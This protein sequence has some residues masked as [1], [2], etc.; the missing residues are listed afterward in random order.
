MKT[1]ARRYRSIV[2]LTIVCALQAEVA[3]A[4]SPAAADEGA[5]HA[6]VVPG[7]RPTLRALGVVDA[8]ERA[9]VMVELIRRLHFSA[10]PPVDLQATLLDLSTAMTDFETLRNAVA[11][12][13]PSPSLKMAADRRSRGKLEDALEAA[14][15]DLKESRRVYRVELRTNDTAAA[16]RRRLAIIGV[17]AEELQRTLN[18][19][20]ELRIE[21]R[22]I[23][24]PLPLSPQT[25]SKIIFE[26]DV[27]P[28]QL[29]SEI[30]NDPSARLLYHGLSGMD[31]GTRRWLAGQPDLL[32]RI[33]RDAEAVR[34]FSLFAAALR[35]HDGH[36]VVPGDA[37]GA[38]RWAAVLDAD[39]AR[40]DRFVRRLLDHN[41]GRT[42]GLYFTIAAVDERRRRF[43]L[44]AAGDA[45][46]ED[47][48]FKRLV[49][50]FANCYPANSTLYPFALRSHDAALMLL[51]IGITN[52]GRLAGPGSRRFWQRALDGDSLPEN[53]AETLRNH[54]EGGVIDAAWLVDTLCGAAAEHRERVFVTVLAGHR[55]FA[56]AADADLPEVLV[57][58][59]ARSL[60]PSVVM[61]MEHARVAS[62]RVIAAVA[63]HAAH[64]ATLEDREP[65]VTGNRLFQGALALTL[66]AIH[67][68]TLADGAG[69]AL[70]ASLAAV[71]PQDGRYHG[72]IADWLF[73]QWLPA[74][75]N[76]TGRD[77]DSIEEA[78][79]DAV[80][81]PVVATPRRVNWEGQDYVIDLAGATRR[82]LR[83]VR[84]K[85]GGITLDDVFAVR[86]IAVAL[87]QPSLTLDQVKALRSDLQKLA[88]RFR[89][90]ARADEYADD[91]VEVD[92]VLGAVARD[93][94]RI[95]EARD[96]R[97]A[98][99]AAAELSRP[100]DFLLAH[101]LGAWAYA[102]LISDAESSALLG[103]DPSLRHQFGVAALGRGKFAQRWDVATSVLNARAVNGSLLGLQ[104][105]LADSSLRRLSAENVPPPPTI[106][107]NDLMSFVL[108]A[109]LS[110]PRRLDDDELA[111]IARAVTAGSQAIAD[112][113]TDASRLSALAI[114][115]AMSPWRRELL[116]W[117]LANEP[118]RLEEQFST[119]ERAR[120]GG[121]AA[122][123]LRD[124]GSVSI[125]T[126]CLCLQPPPARIPEVGIG[127]AADGLMGGQNADLMLRIAVVLADLKMPAEL[128][129]FVLSYAMRDFLDGVAPAHAADFD[130]F[131]RM[132]A[133]VDQRMIE[134][135]LGAVAAVGPLR[136]AEGQR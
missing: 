42:A 92:E 47:S 85:Q 13:G 100:V 90:M 32:R 36:V 50:S 106:G 132:A 99:G 97:R 103:G 83:E 35:V 46:D 65:A 79:A 48:R 4:Q 40:A 29:F 70:L 67:S 38:R 88:T 134:D 51:E 45:D 118:H 19:G 61:A 26:R 112:A 91:G 9:M 28:R 102:P 93:L 20:N 136:P 58:L 49:D 101:A 24:L 84:A 15:L 123:T 81:G 60:Y 23:D 128:A 30:L 17:S 62:P 78:V 7:G 129:P 10:S 52:E 113:G 104:A 74:V 16:L 117:T 55:L 14:G 12:A 66:N 89:G 105:A 31:A 41:G 109:A 59:R 80:A 107:G 44:G 96:L 6:L 120:I 82:R 115:A 69:E 56:G 27:R 77:S 39:P 127:R 94:A 5:W 71:S 124:W 1:H 111:N 116:A 87:R 125:V 2:V 119:T 22:S 64:V 34:A 108:T 75:R 131:Y 18:A 54:Q 11:L 25:W 63:R 121:I 57:A 133:R 130:A 73:D 68:T 76:V 114:T 33:Y 72:R 53:A 135:Y 3:I 98:A 86:R 110:D 8:R 95:D 21:Q 126:G 37:V 43:L 122:E